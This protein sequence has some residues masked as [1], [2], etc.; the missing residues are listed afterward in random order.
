MRVAVTGVTG[1]VGRALADRL[2]DRHAVQECPRRQWDLED[3]NLAGKVAETDFELLLHPAAMSSLEECERDP[4]RAR[5]AHVGGTRSLLGG[6]EGRPVLYFSTDYVLA[7]KAPG[8]KSEEAATAPLSVYARTKWEAEQCVL[9]AGGT[10]MRVSWVFGPEKPAFPESVVKRALAGE[11]LMA[12]DDKY[13]LPCS[14]ADLALWVERWIEVGCPA[15]LF[16]ACQSGPP[17]SW[18]GM[19]VELVEQLWKEGRLDRPVPVQ[20]QSM[21]AMPG[22]VAQRPRHT[23]MATDKLAGMLGW[24][25]RDWREVF[26]QDLARTV[27]VCR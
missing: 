19:A 10:V 26:R 16:H 14:T 13:S 22:F 4:E 7:G 6:L 12:I 25:P 11:S 5:R 20:K 17:V 2:G 23:A 9:E 27:G 15:G 21:A 24:A 3:P 8:L 18:H 1:R